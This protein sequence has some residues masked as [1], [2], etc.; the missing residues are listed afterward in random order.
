MKDK[1][2]TQPKVKAIEPKRADYSVQAD[3]V[4]LL[5]AG[6]IHISDSDLEGWDKLTG[7]DSSL[8]VQV[9]RRN[10]AE[11]AHSDNAAAK[12][13]WHLINAVNQK[14]AKKLDAA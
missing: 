7:S 8:Q 9:S 1:I 10:L 13:A 2:M 5:R 11:I 4:R 6:K 3:L 12:Q 14:A